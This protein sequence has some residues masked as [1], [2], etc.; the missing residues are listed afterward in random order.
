M[1]KP[2]SK[3]GRIVAAL[4]MGV[5]VPFLYFGI[6]VVASLFWPGYSFL[7][8][9]ASTLGSASSR[10]PA[11]FNVGSI[12]VGVLTL[13]ASLAFMRAFQLLRARRNLGDHRILDA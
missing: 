6:Q 9:D 4:G 12:V 10:F 1:E 11:I 5:A 8:Q 13:V 3:E 7:N 2:S